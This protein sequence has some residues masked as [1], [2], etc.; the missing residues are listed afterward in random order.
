M[1]TAKQFSSASRPNGWGLCARD[2]E[3]WRQRSLSTD[4]RPNAQCKYHSNI[5]HVLSSLAQHIALTGLYQCAM[6][7]TFM[8]TPIPNLVGYH[9]AKSQDYFCSAHPHKPPGPGKCSGRNGPTKAQLKGHLNVT[10]FGTGAGDYRMREGPLFRL[11]FVGA[12]FTSRCLNGPTF[13]PWRTLSQ[14]CPPARIH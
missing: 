2:Q 10:Y 9:L 11:S 4:D 1:V 7:W 12:I 8:A 13:R 6:R 3:K 5:S 14:L